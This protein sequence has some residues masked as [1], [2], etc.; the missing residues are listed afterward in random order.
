MSAKIPTRVV[1]ATRGSQLALWQS[2]WVVGRLRDAHPGLEVELHVLKTSGDRF[3]EASLQVLGG[4]GAFTKEITEAILRGEADLA[5]HSLK[6]LPTLPTPGLRVWAFPKRFS[7]R[8]AWI[9]RDG[10][11][12]EEIP[13]GAKVATGS[14]RRT[15]Q[16]KH[17]HPSVEVRQIRGN[18]DTRLRKFAEGS[19]AGMF[20]AMA[21]LE[22]LELTRHV[23]EALP[24]RLF[25]P[26]PGQGSLA[27]EGREE[28]TAQALLSPLNDPDTEDAVRAERALL[29]ELEA[30]CQV[31][32]GALATVDDGSL[33]LDGLVAALD[34]GRLIRNRSRGPR[35]EADS[36]GRSLAQELIAA[37]G[38][39]ILEEIR[40]ESGMDS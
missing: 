35:A 18:V 15:A 21:G 16:L 12:F 22:R 10:L 2:N 26:A 34:G 9:G 28:D 31:P 30:G 36:L 37:G 7:P 23:T 3:Q 39:E 38:G 20:L 19:M 17:R 4:K 32:V 25:L 27:I 1:I 33:V 8:D 13:P 5:V 6:D 14:L 11:R 24:P 40:R 29:A